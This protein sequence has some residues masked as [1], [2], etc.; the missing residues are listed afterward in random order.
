GII[1]PPPEIKKIADKTAQWIVKNGPLF[2]ERIREKEQHNPKFCF[3]NKN[4]PYRA[5][6]DYKIK[7]EA[8]E[9][10]GGKGTEAEAAEKP[11]K[12]KK[13]APK[14]PPPYEFVID[15]PAISA[16]DLDIVKLTA[17]FVAR[18]GREFMVALTKREQ[19]NYQFDFL[20]QNHSLFGFFTKLVEE[21]TKVLI[22]P[23]DHA[24]LRGNV[25][26]RY[27][28]LDRVKGRVEYQVYQEEEKKKADAEADEEKVAY[29]LIDWHDFVIVDTVE[30][31]EAD[32]SLD[33]PAPL[34]LVD[35]ESMTLAQKK[36]ALI[37]NTETPEGDDGGDMDVELLQQM[38]T[39][40]V[41][42]EEG[43]P[44]PEL[45]VQKPRPPKLPEAH[46]PIKI[47][48][49]YVPKLG[50]SSVSENTSICPKCG[51]AI[52]TSDLEEH[53][54]IELLDPKGREQKA[55][56]ESKNRTSNIVQGDA[57]SKSLARFGAFRTD[58][59]GSEE[60]EIGRRVG[61]VAEKEKEAEKSKVIW[62]GHTASIG[63][64]TRQAQQSVSMEEQLAA[65][66]K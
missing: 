46:A 55:A 30:F 22:P 54:R 24:R 17:Q 56:A 6:Y 29:A 20:R 44:E 31:V 38:E 8:K 18:N 53:M 42:M 9:A 60:V 4:D 16:Q 5:Y 43:S 48:T 50:S 64:A 65:L 33:L 1:Y 59:F 47:R 25:E 23:K 10:Q 37:F 15:M 40:D 14:E 49:D 62:D 34:S 52:K 21:Y 12:A 32:E 7:E 11:K 27:E 61:D 13:P 35:L 19:R 39:D 36:A 63:T 2:E 3:L 26:N 41:E 58:I 45:E 66:Q 57:V 51:E 28:I